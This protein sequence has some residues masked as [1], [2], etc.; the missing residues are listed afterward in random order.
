MQALDSDGAIKRAV[1]VAS[2]LGSGIVFLD[3]TIVNV[4]LPAIRVEPQRQ[5]R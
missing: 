1:L 4:A 3:Q 5:P 2:I